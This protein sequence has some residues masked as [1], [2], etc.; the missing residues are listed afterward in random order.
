MIIPVSFILAFL[1]AF[2]LAQ[3]LA[4]KCEG[5][6][7]R[8]SLRLKIRRRYLHIHHWLWSFIAI[9]ALVING[10]WYPIWFGALSGSLLQ[11]LKYR[12]RFVIL[13]HENDFERIYERFRRS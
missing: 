4:G 1:A 3:L 8:R 12:D 2:L 11:G 13:Y 6:K 9:L 7:V 10:H 5:H